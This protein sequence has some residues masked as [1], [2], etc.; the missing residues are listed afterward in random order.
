MI[1]RFFKTFYDF[2]RNLRTTGA[3]YETSHAAERE[4]CSKLNGQTQVVLEFGAGHGNITREILKRLDDDV[5][6]IAF[7]VNPEF[8]KIIQERIDDRRLLVVNDSASNFQRYVTV[9]VDAIISSIPL[10]LISKQTG[11]DI[12]S[13]S[14]QALRKGGYFSQVL[15]SRWHLSKFKRFFQRCSY[16]LLPN[17]PPE[18]VY[19]CQKV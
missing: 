18:F 6:L 4:I 7:E 1:G 10:T 3:V 12:I 14:Y 17:L 13:N 9:P 15:Y 2:T 19:H 8:C 11:I 16:V 5:R